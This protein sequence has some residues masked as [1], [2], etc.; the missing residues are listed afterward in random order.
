MPCCPRNQSAIVGT[1]RVSLD[2]GVS[3]E[4]QDRWD[5]LGDI[6]HLTRTVIV[7]GN[8]P[9]GFLGAA[10]WQL[11]E[12]RSWPQANWFAPGMIYGGFAHLTDTAIG[13]RA[14]YRP[15]NFTVRIREDRLPAPLIM[16]HFADN[17]SLAVLN[18]TPHGDTTAADANDV[19]G[20]PLVDARFQ[21]GAVGGEERDDVLIVGYWFP[22]SEGE[23]TYAG[24]TYPGGQL[25]QWRR[26]FHPIQ[27]GLTQQ[28]EVAFRVGRG[29]PFT[30]AYPRAWRW[31]WQS[32]HPAV[33]TQDLSA[34]RRAVVDVLAR[35]IV[36]KDG[37][38]GIPNYIET[39]VKSAPPEAHNMVLGFCGKNLEAAASC[40]AKPNWIQVRGKNDCADWARRS[41]LPF[42]R[43]RSR[44][45]QARV[46][47]WALANRSAHWADLRSICA[48]LVT[49]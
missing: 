25:H 47:I 3:I 26:R 48:R 32:L 46:F 14:H 4:F 9:G 23:V 17:S 6:L 20:V 37:R 42:Y 40:Y 30:E 29:E 28:V 35:N 31:A 49:I 13:G 7:H 44:R 16:A 41:S 5:S 21:F 15:G 10:T 39:L 33:T 19:T 22:G 34:A 11:A 12:P 8:A 18:P 27:D 24:N 43:S 36:E 2:G 38:A 45:P 1:G